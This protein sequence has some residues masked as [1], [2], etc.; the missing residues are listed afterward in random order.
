MFRPK[1]CAHKKYP[2]VDLQQSIPVHQREYL[3]PSRLEY[4]P[5][6]DQNVASAESSQRPG[7]RRRNTL[8]VGNIAFQGQGCPAL[9]L[10]LFS[11]PR[12][13]I[14]VAVNCNDP[15]TDG[16]EL[17]RGLPANTACRPSNDAH[18]IMQPQPVSIIRVHEFF[19]FWP[20]KSP[21][22]DRTLECQC[23]KS[24][25]DRSSGLSAIS[26]SAF[27]E[28]PATQANPMSERF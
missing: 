14:A 11:C 2:E 16:R 3:Q 25:Y 27:F 4:A 12:A 22:Q 18:P 6:V 17:D 24:Q 28:K 8:G 23:P 19:S 20:N 26:F 7:R 1:A 21:P 13:T 15:S 10:N 9:L 5:V